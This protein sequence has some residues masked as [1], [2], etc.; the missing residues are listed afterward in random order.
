MTFSK[1]AISV[2]ILGSIALGMSN[3]HALNADSVINGSNCDFGA[4]G[5]SNIIGQNSALSYNPGVP[6][7]ESAHAYYPHDQKWIAEGPMQ[8]MHNKGSIYN[9]GG[10]RF[11]G[12]GM[13]LC[14][15]I[16]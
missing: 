6:T 7:S 1:I 12:I 2:T 15:E 9:R 13:A 16:E 10:L 11:A 14:S 4:F 5:P 8:A 3:A